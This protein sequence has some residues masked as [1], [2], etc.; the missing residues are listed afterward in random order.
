MIKT[1]VHYSVVSDAIRWARS[2]C[3]SYQG[4]CTHTTDAAYYVLEFADESDV[5]MF[6]LRWS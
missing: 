2:H 3:V 1:K 5:V 6:A 4:H